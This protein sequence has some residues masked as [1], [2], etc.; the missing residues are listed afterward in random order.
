M[1]ESV[2]FLV[3][4]LGGKSLPL[5]HT[6]PSGIGSTVAER[7]E[8]VG[9]WF[10]LANDL[11]ASNDRNFFDLLFGPLSEFQSK[12]P[13]LHSFPRTF[14]SECSRKQ[15]AL[16]LVLGEL[17]GHARSSRSEKALTRSSRTGELRTLQ[18]LG[19]EARVGSNSDE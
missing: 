17:C 6:K 19:V 11:C 7:T 1:G 10:L 15:Q 8:S 2:L 16:F 3:L 5:T 4:V 12:H 14:P 18:A 13:V 9:S